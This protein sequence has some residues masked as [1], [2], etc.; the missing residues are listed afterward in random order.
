MSDISRK[1]RNCFKTPLLNK[2]LRNTTKGQES[3]LVI[4]LELGGKRYGNPIVWHFEINDDKIN[5]EV[6]N[7]FAKKPFEIE[8]LFIPS[9]EIISVHKGFI[10]TYQK[11]ELSFDETY[12]DLAVALEATPLINGAANEAE[13]LIKGL[14]ATI[15]VEVR[16][17]EDKF[18]ITL[19]NES[20]E[21][22][23]H[24]VAQGINKLAQLI[25]LIENGSLTKDTI[26][27]WDEPEANLNPKYILVVAKFLQTLANAGCQIFVATHDYLLPYE[28][29]NS[30]EYK[31]VI[32]E[33]VPDMKFFSLYKGEDGTEVEEGATMSDLHHDAIMDGLGIHNEREDILFRK[34][35]NPKA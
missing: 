12:F 30:V 6:L 28:L 22:E 3:H 4:T 8:S 18:L 11:R 32:E 29:S 2:L 16:K 9:N 31:D 24:F 13:N 5:H 27:F 23:A 33:E 10:S 35:V 34:S 21:L 20:Q 25:R 15:G 26:L 1:L 17:P 14:K 19:K 7:E